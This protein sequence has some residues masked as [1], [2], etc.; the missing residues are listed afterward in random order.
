MAY[1]GNKTLAPRINEFKLKEQMCD[2]GRRIWL[3]GFCAGNEGN[4]SHRI[5]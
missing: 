5:G 2:V 4:H 3:K 1:N